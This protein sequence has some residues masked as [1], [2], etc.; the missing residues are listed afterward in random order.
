MR[1]IQKVNFAS[2]DSL[3]QVLAGLKL[4]SGRKSN[5]MWLL[6]ESLRLRLTAKSIGY[7]NPKLHC[8][9]RLPFKALSGSIIIL[10]LGWGWSLDPVCHAWTL[11][12]SDTSS[13]ILL[14]L[15]VCTPWFLFH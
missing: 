5:R 1:P 3:L 14:V 8:L 6:A 10:S 2:S 11:L 4:A 7:N 13:L 9:P 12:R 15:G